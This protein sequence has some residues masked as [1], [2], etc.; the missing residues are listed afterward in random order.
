MPASLSCLA[1][2]TDMCP[3]DA[4]R[5]RFVCSATSWACSRICSGVIIA[6]IG[7]SASAK[8][9]WAQKPQSSAQPPDLALTSEHMSVES[10]KRSSRTSQARSTRAPMSSWSV[11]APSSSASSKLISGGIRRPPWVGTPKSRIVPGRL[12][13]AELLNDLRVALRPGAEDEQNEIVV[14]GLEGANDG[15]RDPDR[16][17]RA[18]LLDLVVELHPAGSGDHD[19]DLLHLPVLVSEGLTLAGLHHLVGDAAAFRVQIL[20]R[21][22]S[23]DVVG[24]AAV[25]CDVLDLPQVFDRVV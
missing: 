5:L 9:D 12:L 24:D 1:R 8:R 20:V 23:L 25:G 4:Q 3:I 10:P 6:C 19:V 2:S 18:D 17:E 7:V 21:E 22:A 11:R 13:P 16:V 15:R 14:P